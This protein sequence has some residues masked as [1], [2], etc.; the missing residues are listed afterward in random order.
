MFQLKPNRFSQS[1]FFRDLAM[2]KFRIVAALST[3]LMV[4][5]GAFWVYFGGFY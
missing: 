4:Q 1:Q 5:S 3:G 2:N